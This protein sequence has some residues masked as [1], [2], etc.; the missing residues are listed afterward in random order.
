MHWSNG[1]EASSQWDMVVDDVERLVVAV[2]ES[3]SFFF[4]QACGNSPLAQTP[5]SLKT[6]P[7]YDSAE[8]NAINLGIF[9]DVWERLSGAEMAYMLFEWTA[10]WSSNRDG[11]K[12]PLILLQ[13][14]K[15]MANCSSNVLH[16][17][18]ERWPPSPRSCKT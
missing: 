15:Q 8:V 18:H 7:T 14:S 2:V 16:R 3:G 6:N 1:L 9:E 13:G 5:Q 11:T 4:F 12:T 17:P 10:P